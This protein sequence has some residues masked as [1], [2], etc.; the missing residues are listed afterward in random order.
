VVGDDLVKWNNET[1]WKYRLH[2]S[3]DFML[4]VVAEKR[5]VNKDYDLESM[6]DL[7]AAMWRSGISRCAVLL[8]NNNASQFYTYI[9]FK[10]NFTC[11]DTSPVFIG[12][13]PEGTDKAFDSKKVRCY[14]EA[15]LEL[16]DFVIL[17]NL[18]AVKLGTESMFS[19][20]RILLELVLSNAISLVRESMAYP[21]MD[22]KNPR[23]STWI[24]MHFGCQSSV[25][26]ASENI[27]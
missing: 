2:R 15:A 13:C 7:F 26:H 19:K 3:N 25:I 4:V 5:S 10:N 27:Y 18:T 21:Y 16:L 14:G 23:L 6:E 12:D 9:P 8:V 11:E 20:L 17:S 1:V 22:F 24:S